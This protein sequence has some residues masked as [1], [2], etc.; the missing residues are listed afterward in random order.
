[1]IENLDIFLNDETNNINIYVGEDG[2][3]HFV[4][5]DG[6]DTVL[7]FNSNTNPTALYGHTNTNTVETTYRMYAG[8]KRYKNLYVKGYG[9]LNAGISLL[10]MMNNGDE[11]REQ[12]SLFSIPGASSNTPFDDEKI[13]DISSDEYLCDYLV[14]QCRTYSIGRPDYT[15][16]FEWSATE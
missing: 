16:Y 15:C 7:N 4:D 13:I 3:L 12:L 10:F 11:T 5:K 9:T 6:A 14:Y 8:Y 2:K 1:M